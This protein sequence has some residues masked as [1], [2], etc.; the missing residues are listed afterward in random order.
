MA[1]IGSNIY[2]ME[3][4]SQF[5]QDN[6][7][8]DQYTGYFGENEGVVIIDS[9]LRASDNFRG[10]VLFRSTN[11]DNSI[12]VEQLSR[13]SCFGLIPDN[14]DPNLSGVFSLVGPIGKYDL[15]SD[16]SGGSIE[17]LVFQIHYEALPIHKTDHYWIS[18]V[19][20]MNANLTW[21][22]EIRDDNTI[23]WFDVEL[24]ASLNQKDEKVGAIKTLKLSL[25][26]MVFRQTNENEKRG[27]PK[28]SIQSHC[29][30]PSTCV[31]G[32]GTPVKECRLPIKFVSLLVNPDPRDSNNTA[33]FKKV[34]IATIEPLCNALI[35]RVRVVWRDQVALDLTV[36]PNKEDYSDNP[37][38]FSESGKIDDGVSPAKRPTQ[39]SL[40]SADEVKN[41]QDSFRDPGNWG[42]VEVY[43]VN[44]LVGNASGGYT[45][46]A[47]QATALCLLDVNQAANNHNLLAHEIGHVLGLDDNPVVTGGLVV[48]SAGSI[49]ANSTLNVNTGLHSLFLQKSSFVNAIVKHTQVDDCSKPCASFPPCP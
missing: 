44:N 28:N 9:N 11:R 12:A 46:Y 19:E 43:L 20:S 18:E 34:D 1:Q 13:L 5:F 7:L 23:V 6:N 10:E 33:K 3:D 32:I 31:G 29:G 17:S 8:E 27:E 14:P 21:K 25:P 26:E 41:F 4:E 35:D 38:S 39:V 30:P 49:M 48:G 15:R 37:S 16:P 40:G 42:H 2:Q 45:V 36:W 22:Q 24:S 47:G